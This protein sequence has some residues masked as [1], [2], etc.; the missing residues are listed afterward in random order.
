M[1]KLI[2]NSWFNNLW[3][4][5]C[6]HHKPQGVQVYTRLIKGLPC[7]M[8]SALVDTC[9]SFQKPT[10]R[11]DSRWLVKLEYNWRGL[12]AYFVWRSHEEQMY[13]NRGVGFPYI[14]TS[15]NTRTVQ[16]RSAGYKL[17]I[18]YLTMEDLFDTSTVALLFFKIL[19]LWK[20]Q[21]CFL[22]ADVIMTSPEKKESNQWGSSSSAAN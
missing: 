13:Q 11:V 15:S 17:A 16:R 1:C 18:Q 19:T 8:Y 6:V 10:L 9:Q 12:A 21:I 22:F 3:K 20:L 7:F 4:D 2:I 14:D 5:G